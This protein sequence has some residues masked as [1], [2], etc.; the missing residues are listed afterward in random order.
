[1][2]LSELITTLQIMLKDHGDI[3]VVDANNYPIEEVSYDD[4]E[5]VGP[6][7]QLFSEGDDH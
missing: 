4:S 3:T 1:M 2:E 7:V 6:A 5:E